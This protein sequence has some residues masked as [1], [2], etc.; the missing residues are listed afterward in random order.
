MG[1]NVNVVI[2]KSSNNAFGMYSES[3]NT[4]IIPFEGSGIGRRNVFFHEITHALSKK[5]L[6]TNPVYK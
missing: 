6:K 1:K 3:S 5:E 4:I 2:Q